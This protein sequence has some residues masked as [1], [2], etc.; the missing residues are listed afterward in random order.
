MKK[1][2]L[3]LLLSSA[4]VSFAQTYFT[5]ASGIQIGK[6]NC[7][8]KLP[9]NNLLIG[10]DNGLFR[11]SQGNVAVVLPAAI[12][13]VSDM[14]TDNS[15]F[16]WLATT[17][18][19]LMKMGS[20]GTSLLQSWNV[21]NSVLPYELK[22]IEFDPANGIWLGNNDSI[23][24]MNGTQFTGFSFA[25]GPIFPGVKDI[26]Q[27][28]GQTFFLI[29]DSICLYN[30]SGFSSINYGQFAFLSETGSGEIFT[31]DDNLIYR[32][33]GASFI[34]DSALSS[35]S[36]INLL[37]TPKDDVFDLIKMGNEYCVF[38][39]DY[40]IIAANAMPAQLYF[41]SSGFYL[42]GLK[43]H[44]IL[45]DSPQLYIG[46]SDG[47]LVTTDQ[48]FATLKNEYQYLDLYRLRAPI[49]ANGSLFNFTSA[50]YG[51]VFEA[52]AGSGKSPMYI[53]MPWM[54]G[55]DQNNQLHLA[56]QRYSQVGFDFFPGTLRVN[57]DEPSENPDHARVWKVSKAE[58]D[59]HATHWNQSG[60]VAPEAIMSWPGN[61]NSLYDEAPILAPFADINQ[62]GYYE[63]TQG[64]Y[65]VIRGEQ[66]IYFIYNDA[67]A[68]H[69][70][71]GGEALGIEIHG[72]A[73][74]MR[75][76]SSVTG[77]SNT[78]NT[79]FLHY[80][81]INRS[82]NDY[83][84]LKLAV[85]S[86]I[87]IGYAYNDFAG[88]D[89]LLDSYFIY[90]SS[91]C[92]S[93]TSQNE[94]AYSDVLPAM[95]LTFLSHKM[96]SFSVYNNTGTLPSYCVDPETATHYWNV[97]NGLFR[98]GS[99]MTYGGN[100]YSGTIPVKY[101][102]PGDPIDST[103]W[104]D[105]SSGNLPYDRRG[106][107]VVKFDSLGA[108]Q[109]VCLDFAYVFDDEINGTDNTVNVT[110]L[111]RRIGDIRTF[112]YN[113]QLECLYY[114]HNF[115]QTQPGAYVDTLLAFVDTCAIDPYSPVD[116]AWIQNTTTVGNIVY[117]DWIVT[118]HGDTLHFDHVPYAL[119]N[120][121][122]QLFVLVLR[123]LFDG[124]GSQT[125]FVYL[126]ASSDASPEPSKPIL[127]MSLYPNPSSDYITV[128]FPVVQFPEVLQIID[129]NGQIVDS[130]EVSASSVSIPV[131]R[132]A[133]GFYLI[134]AVHSNESI[135][136]CIQR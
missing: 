13:G 64:E 18:A 28:G 134:R 88:C 68:P 66:A 16:V 47:F 46:F 89:T 57:S 123:C 80:T 108:G 54:A 87:D 62:N 103:Q 67:A 104:S 24:L 84:Q 100:G 65:P 74:V 37:P 55:L 90:N 43:W 63:P 125:H 12:H 94:H 107:G 45:S 50:L 124:R 109:S 95:G 75:D 85:F 21:V 128:G 8:L 101:M 10:S 53:A 135:P 114:E 41:P 122:N 82:Q 5:E 116:T 27:S 48:Y 131:N 86:D 11:Y 22:H 60:Y 119:Q 31:C 111:K 117:V 78:D 44:S 9:N 4:Y 115:M 72:M 58:I 106:V 133:S 120:S 26:L 33:N 23:W 36:T 136:F 35:G 34:C 121:G 130:Y 56:A 1:I 99:P 110:M 71:S 6:V 69:S 38:S 77:I 118:Q 127:E 51:P 79:I 42:P 2:I 59:F 25:T 32:Y 83:H 81:I 61:G 92:D 93:V 17:N 102:F 105:M 39:P 70:E 3:V 126:N 129:V 52:P 29:N 7:F 97:M 112:F 98:D 96:Q 15:G 73:Y 49:M 14:T 30:G 76:S 132:F 20:N 19:G 113:Q 40:V 91:G